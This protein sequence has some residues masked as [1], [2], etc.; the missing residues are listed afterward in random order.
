MTKADDQLTNHQEECMKLLELKFV[1]KNP[2]V[3]TSIVL[4]ILGM[5]TG[6][7]AK[8]YSTEQVQNERL[9]SVEI[10]AT[11]VKK[12]LVYI[13]EDKKH[14]FDK[15]KVILDNQQLIINEIKALKRK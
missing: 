8:Y 2:L 6:I 7:M 13:E 4:V 1:K 14:R 5:L 12:I 10:A 15:D 11:D 3:S 9:F